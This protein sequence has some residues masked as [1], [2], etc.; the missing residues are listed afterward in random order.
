MGC[1]V[2]LGFLRVQGL[3]L[4]AGLEDDVEVQLVLEGL[5]HPGRQKDK[6]KSKSGPLQGDP[7]ILTEI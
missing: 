7:N 1:K 3:G 2:T 6:A 5:V 4:G